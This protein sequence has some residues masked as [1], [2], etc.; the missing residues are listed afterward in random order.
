MKALW[1]EYETQS[2]A[3]ARLVKDIDKLEMVIQA[4]EYEQ[5][6]PSLDLEDFFSSTAGKIRHPTLQ[7]MDAELRQRREAARQARR[8]V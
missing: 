4:F 8:N 3:E 7:K 5:T 1:N 6:H 2:S